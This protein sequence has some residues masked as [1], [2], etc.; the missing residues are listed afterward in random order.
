MIPRYRAEFL[1]RLIVVLSAFGLVLNSVLAD[2]RSDSSMAGGRETNIKALRAQVESFRKNSD[3]EQAAKVQERIHG[4]HLSQEGET[5]PVTGAARERLEMLRKAAALPQ[6][7]Q[8]ELGRSDAEYDRLLTLEKKRRFDEAIALISARKELFAEHLG[9]ESPSVLGMRFH[10]ARMVAA[11][12]RLEEA[13]NQLSELVLD[14]RAQFGD[15]HYMVASVLHR[16]ARTIQS[17]ARYSEAEPLYREAI[18]IHAKLVPVPDKYRAVYVNDLGSMLIRKGDLVRSEVVLR[19]ALALHI[20]AYGE[21]HMYTTYCMNNLAKMYYDSG[22]YR[23][24]EQR[25]REVVAIQDRLRSE[26]GEYVPSSLNNLGACLIKQGLLDEGTSVLRRALERRCGLCPRNRITGVRQLPLPGQRR[27]RLWKR[28]DHADRRRRGVPAQ[29][30]AT[31][32]QL[33]V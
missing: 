6:A 18:A 1:K 29:W 2:D 26:R 30:V 5:A 33:P 12:G 22:Q 23:K 10:R 15:D 25:F 8:H 17:Q 9:E 11:S 3:Y 13:T 20:A 16:L 31:I 14:Y 21:M 4:Y 24:A 19:E 7:V 28:C 32:H 27:R